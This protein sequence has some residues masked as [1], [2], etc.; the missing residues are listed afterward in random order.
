MS[1]LVG[2]NWQMELLRSHKAD[3]PI[4]F[5][6]RNLS[7]SDLAE[8]SA[9]G[10]G[11]RGLNASDS[12]LWRSRVDGSE[13]IEL[14]TLSAPHLCHEVVAGRQKTG[15]DG[16]RAWEAVEDYLVDSAGG[17]PIPIL[18]EDRNEADPD[19][20]ADGQSMALAVCPIAWTAA[21]LRLYTP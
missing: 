15:S 16:R 12:S 8:Y 7:R 17:M 13:R 19:W 14:T 20:A 11:W 9:D 6:N 3:P 21:S 1:I 5:L 2:V 4:C 18:S 10:R